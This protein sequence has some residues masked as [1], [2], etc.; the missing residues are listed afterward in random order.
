MAKKI[1]KKIVIYYKQKPIN[2]VN[3][4]K[5]NLNKNNINLLIIYFLC[6]NKCKDLLLIYLQFY[7]FIY[8]L[9]FYNLQ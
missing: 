6:N 7:L 1:N 3:I 9:K 8:L 2:I 4:K 5:N